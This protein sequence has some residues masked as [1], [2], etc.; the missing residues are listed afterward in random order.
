MEL[1]PKMTACLPWVSIP[2]RSSNDTIPLGVAGKKHGKSTSQ[3]CLRWILDRGAVMAVGTGA[4]ATTAASYAQEN[5]DIFD[6]SL[7]AD[8]VQQLDQLKK[9]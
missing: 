7:T 4:N 9:E 8:E 3:V 2:A 1:R 5:L 6:F